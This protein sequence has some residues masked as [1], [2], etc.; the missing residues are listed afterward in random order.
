MLLQ[1]VK[2]TLTHLEGIIKKVL[3][4]GASGLIGSDLIEAIKASHEVRTYSRRF[5]SGHEGVQADIN[6]NVALDTAMQGIH[7]VVHLA[8]VLPDSDDDGNVILPSGPGLGMELNWDY[9]NDN[10]VTST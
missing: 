6:D 2:I 7:T 1:A 9:I 5:V 3:V 8:A 10:L 4:T